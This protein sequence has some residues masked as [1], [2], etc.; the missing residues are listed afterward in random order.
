[1]NNSGLQQSVPFQQVNH[2]YKSSI[3]S[4]KHFSLARA[5]LQFQN[6]FPNQTDTSNISTNQK[7]ET[8]NQ[9]H[10]MLI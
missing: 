7:R 5:N 6:Q 2:S 1:M 4:G 3:A 10:A 9:K 8:L